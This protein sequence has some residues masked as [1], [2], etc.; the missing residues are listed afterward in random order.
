MYQVGRELLALPIAFCISCAMML[1]TRNRIVHLYIVSVG[2]DGKWSN[3][4]SM[5][6]HNRAVIVL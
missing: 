4:L 2:G 5:Q 6:W 3:G 1:V